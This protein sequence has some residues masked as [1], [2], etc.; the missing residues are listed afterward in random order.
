MIHDSLVAKLSRFHSVSNAER[1]F[2]GQGFTR[3][4]AYRSGQAIVE[5]G[6]GPADSSLVV[7]GFA[8][9]VKFLPDGA[10]QIL[11]FHIPGDFCDLHSFL[12]RRMDHGIEALTDCRIA[13]MPHHKVKEI[14][15][16]FP[17]LTRS[18]WWDTALDAAILR[19]WMISMGRRTAFEQIGHLLCEM[20][21]RLQAVGLSRENSYE[22]PLSQEQLGDAFGLSI[23][24]VNRMLQA[25]RG[26]RLILTQ[27]RHVTIPDFAALQ[28]AVGF[29]PT[30]LQPRG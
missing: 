29:D 21:L 26:A 12:L 28:E 22:L 24:H 30:Y 2:L 1:D 10:R 17:D 23:V 16:R 8:G 13:K 6:S 27:G 9:R 15:D 20:L 3:V 25:L 14:T 5:E 18:L 4:V 11:A 7:E 19:E